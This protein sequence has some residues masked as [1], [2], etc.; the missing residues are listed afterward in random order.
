[1]VKRKLALYRDIWPI[2]I[3]AGK[4]PVNW[5]GWPEKKRFSLILTH[6]VESI[7]GVGKCLDLADLE[8]RFGFRSS[9][10]FVIKDYSV[11][12]E[13]RQNL[14]DRGFE[15]GVHGY[16]HDGRFFQ[17]KRNIFEKSH[18]INRFLSEWN[19]VGYRSPSMLG[20]LE[21]HRKLHIEY[22]SSTFDTDPFE[23]KPHGVQTVFPF[24]V[25]DNEQ[26]R[27]FVELPYTLPQ[28]FTLYIIMQ[29]KSIDIWKKKLD[30][31]A[32]K[33]G[34]ALVITHPDYMNFSR[35]KS[36]INEYPI[37][38]YEEFLEYIKSRY[39][40]QYWHVLP[41]EIARFWHKLKDNVL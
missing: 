13:L 8:E 6:D 7:I 41:K 28:D 10:N 16:T 29:E 17:D 32:E 20:D 14:V 35:L 4:T 33:G 3:N 21:W 36:G 5:C 38:F 22:D 37:K 18:V 11:T 15:V 31:I 12:P 23:P 26:D 39:E 9:F 19:A 30:W 2:D 34:M 25:E 27:G 1:L 40:G 24:L